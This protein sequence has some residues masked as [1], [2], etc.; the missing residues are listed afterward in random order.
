MSSLFVYVFLICVDN[1]CKTIKSVDFD[2][3]AECQSKTAILNG[4]Y[5]SKVKNVKR[6][7]A[8]CYPKGSEPE[9]AEL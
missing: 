2:S 5:F 8:T 6:G 4:G 7:V 9:T 1:Q 3:M